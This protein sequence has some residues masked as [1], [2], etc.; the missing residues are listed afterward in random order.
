M[1]TEMGAKRTL[2]DDLRTELA[3]PDRCESMHFRQVIHP[4]QAAGA[5]RGAA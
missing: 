4:R 5:V 3:E 1:L 2:P